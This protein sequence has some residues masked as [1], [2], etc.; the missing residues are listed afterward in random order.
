MSG[1][2]S[3]ARL[4]RMN[5]TMAA[6]VARGDVGG[7]VTL[8]SRRGETV[9]EAHGTLA[10]GG[11]EPMRRDTIFRIASMTK[12][13]TAAAAMI[14]VE[15][16]RIRLD[17]PVDRWLPELANRQVLKSLE[18]PLDD[19]VPAERPITMRDLLTFRAG[20]GAIMVFPSRHPIQKAMDEAGLAPTPNRVNLAPDEFMKRLG[21]LPLVH[22]PGAQWLYHTG[23]EVLGVLIARAAGQS[24]GTFMRER[25]FEPLGMR[26]TAFDVP[27]GEVGRMPEVH[28]YD[29]AA[30]K[31]AVFDNAKAA[32]F[33]TPAIFEA[34]GGGLLST[35]DDYLR[36]CRMMLDKG[37]H[38]GGRILSRP[39]VELM[40]T[41]QLTASQKDGAKLFFGDSAG[42]GFGM[43]V[44]TRRTDLYGP[45]RFGWD[46]GYGTS[47]HSD[48]AEDL[49]GILL[50]QRMMDSPS[51][52][53]A[54]VDFWT[55][56][57]QAIDD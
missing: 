37:R 51:P 15:E 40:T 39:S 46:G 3:A 52:P 32:N 27:P 29:A 30:G 47:A 8:V 11:T 10:L 42:W 17:D 5:A 4:K 20:F 54:F 43:G 21:A 33:A 23:S 7:M 36:F 49:I 9:V 35:A 12:P 18:G 24:L 16:C 1:G 48:P 19:T 31:L 41:D 53:K 2:F 25:I 6:H 34:G 44:V 50:T 55:S 38:A 57:Y 26:D 22:Q 14:L 56:A 28:R 13:I 45:G